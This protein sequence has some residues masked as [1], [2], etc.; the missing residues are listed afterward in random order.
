MKALCG[1]LALGLMAAPAAAQIE[2]ARVTG[3]TV[4]GEIVGPLAEFKGVPY[5]AP[6]V[7]PNRW[8]APQPLAPW[9]GVRQATAFGPACMQG[10][11]L[12]RQM[13]SK[14]PLSEDCLYI[15]VWT[16][17]K[18]RTDKLPVIAWIYGGGFNSGMSSVPLYDGAHFAQAGVVFVSI[19]YR[20]GPFGFLA[21]PELSRESGHGSGNWGLLDMIKGLHWVHDNIAQFGGN[22]ANVTIMGHSAGAMAVSNLLA[23]PLARGLFQRA[24]A[25]S[26]SSFAPPQ[27]APGQAGGM[28]SALAYAEAGDSAWLGTLGAHTLAEARALPAGAIDAGQR[29]PGAPRFAPVADGYVI[30]GDQYAL[31]QARRFAD[32]PVLV[33]TNSLESA[34]F[35]GKPVTAA[36]FE[37]QVRAQYG[38]H[39]GPVLAAYPH[40]T[41][42]QASLAS[43]LLATD[44]TFAWNGYT[45]ARL[46]AANGPAPVYA[47]YF[48]WPTAQSPDG[49]PHGAEVALVFG[50][51][52]ARRTAWTE[53]D[54]ALSRAL[55]GYWVNFARNG[56]PNGPGLPQWPRFA[57]NQPTVMELGAQTRP[58]ALPMAARLAA[59][60]PYFAARRTGGKP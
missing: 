28:L 49:S 21:T 43:K 17:A 7:G 59:L 5:A 18:A 23:S 47:Y 22:P 4:A 19:N 32:V 8:R 10:E 53:A 42:A 6:P 35:G 26:G 39:A 29:A 27:T 31:W 36:Q 41:D 50:N 55:H 58:V 30:P 45:W 12:A 15:D 60:D 48:H 52:D 1:A 9:T 16:P 56:N 54:R 24:I 40:A 11:Q 44:A 46:Q 38:A 14:A 51:E 2:Q 13:G 25:E 57:A 20:V 34:A 33:G 3:G 37:Q